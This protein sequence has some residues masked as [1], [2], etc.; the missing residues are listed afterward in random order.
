MIIIS[1]TLEQWHKRLEHVNFKILRYMLINLNVQD[2]KID[3]KIS[4]KKYDIF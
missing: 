3:N 1:I 4:I 2:L